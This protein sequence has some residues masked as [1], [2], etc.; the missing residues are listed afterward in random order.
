MEPLLQCFS[1]CDSQ[2]TRQSVCGFRRKALKRFLSNIPQIQNLR[3]I[4]TVRDPHKENTCASLVIFLI[5]AIYFRCLC[6]CQ[7]HHCYVLQ[8]HR[9]VPNLHDFKC[10][11]L[12]EVFNQKSLLNFWVHIWF[13]YPELTQPPNTCHHSQ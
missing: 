12:K 9:N 2:L 13:R 11:L 10:V 6:P 8:R 4:M 7:N 5:T 1:S 3:L